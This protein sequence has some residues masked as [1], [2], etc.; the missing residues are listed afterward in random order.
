[1]G[2]I[3]DG[4]MA[5]AGDPGAVKGRKVTLSPVEVEAVLPLIRRLGEHARAEL[6]RRLPE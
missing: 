6:K 4:Y 3:D 1:M 5:C 2:V